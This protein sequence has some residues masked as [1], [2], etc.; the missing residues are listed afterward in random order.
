MMGTNE[1][2][3]G[4]YGKGSYNTCVLVS[5]FLRL[6]Y[7]PTLWLNMYTDEQLLCNKLLQSLLYYGDYT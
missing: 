3:Q 5:L 2:M 7:I 1:R 4:Q 6:S